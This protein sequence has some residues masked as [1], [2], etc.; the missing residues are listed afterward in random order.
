MMEGI[1]AL[2]KQYQEEGDRCYCRSSFLGG[3]S[4]VLTTKLRNL[5]ILHKYVKKFSKS[6]KDSQIAWLVAEQLPC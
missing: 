1:N 4:S 6:G 5:L 2:R 3:T